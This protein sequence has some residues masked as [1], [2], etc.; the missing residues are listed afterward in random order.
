MAIRYTPEFRQQILDLV[1]AGRPV[2][3]LV[4]QY[5]CTATTIHGWLRQDSERNSK[6]GQPL[7]NIERDELERLRRENQVL[8]QERDILSKAAAWF[9]QETI[10]S[11]RRTSDS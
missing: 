6:P 9:A 7:T 10:P 2:Q 11:S 4:R 1:K 3:D 5:G 8:R